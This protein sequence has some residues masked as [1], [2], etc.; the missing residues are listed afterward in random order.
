MKQ[1]KVMFIVKRLSARSRVSASKKKNEDPYVL[2]RLDCKNRKMQ[3]IL[4]SI[5]HDKSI[6]KVHEAI[7]LI[8]KN[9]E[10]YKGTHLSKLKKG[11]IIA[12]T[13]DNLYAIYKEKETKSLYLLMFIKYDSIKT[14]LS[15]MK[16]KG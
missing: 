1:D 7:G 3:S 2:Y 16:K 12:K 5:E 10:P 8:T 14:S 4:K 11:S 13:Q 9:G 15:G 6:E